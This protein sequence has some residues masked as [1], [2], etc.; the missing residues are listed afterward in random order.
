VEDGIGERCS[1]LQERWKLLLQEV[2][3]VFILSRSDLKVLLNLSVHGERSIQR[4]SVTKPAGT[5][6]EQVFLVAQRLFLLLPEL[7]QRVVVSVVI[8][9]LRNYG[10]SIRLCY[11]SAGASHLVVTLRN[12]LSDALADVL[13]LNAGGDHSGFDELELG[14][15]GF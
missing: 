11:A 3:P 12:G 15:K 6:L 7:V 13:K 9:Q 8:D 10:I 2:I 5:H 14:C 1:H 4:S